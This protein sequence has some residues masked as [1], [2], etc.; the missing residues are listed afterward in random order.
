VVDNIKDNG[1]IA[2]PKVTC[3]CCHGEKKILV[4][5]RDPTSNAPEDMV[6]VAV[7]HE[8]C[9]HCEGTGEVEAEVEENGDK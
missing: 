8:E 6:V 3:P 2:M 1:D 7:T 9:S 4:F 5:E